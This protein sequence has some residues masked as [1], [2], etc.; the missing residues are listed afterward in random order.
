MSLGSRSDVDHVVWMNLTLVW[1][2]RQ[3]EI[4]QL[5]CDSPGEEWE[6]TLEEVQIYFDTATFDDIE[7]DKKVKSDELSI[8][9]GTMG[10]LTGFSV[11]SGFE[12]IFYLIKLISSSVSFTWADVVAK[13]K[14]MI[15]GRDKRRN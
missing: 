11:I 6:S 8:I 3:C 12:I 7:R 14:K 13:T 4:I 5:L 10:L 2:L 1:Q 15:E 9:G